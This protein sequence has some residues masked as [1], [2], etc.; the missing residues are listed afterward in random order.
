MLKQKK[1]L[2]YEQYVNDILQKLI[3]FNKKILYYDAKKTAATLIYDTLECLLKFHSRFGGHMI[4][5]IFKPFIH[6]VIKRF[7]EN[8]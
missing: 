8:I 4:K 1:Y 6:K 7:A 3:Y 5:F 2:K